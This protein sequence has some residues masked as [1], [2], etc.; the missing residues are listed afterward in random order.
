NSHFN[1]PSVS[2]SDRFL[3]IAAKVTSIRLDKILPDVLV[4]AML[5]IGSSSPENILFPALN[6]LDC[7]GNPQDDLI[8]GL[9]AGSP[10]MTIFISGGEQGET[11]QHTRRLLSS[12]LATQSQVQ[13]IAAD[14]MAVP[15]LGLP[16]V[17]QAP[18]LRSLAYNGAFT[19]GD[20]AKLIQNCQNLDS[21]TFEGFT[22]G[23]IAPNPTASL[24]AP[25]L[26]RLDLAGLD[27]SDITI[28]IL[29]S[30]I[31]PQLM[32]LDVTLD[33]VPLFDALQE[34]PSAP[35][36]RSAFRLLAE[37]SHCLESLALATSITLRA[38]VLAAFRS[39]RSLDI[40]DWTP[41]CQLDDSDIHSLCHSL[42]KLRRF[43]LEY[44][45]SRRPLSVDTKITPKSFGFFARYTT[46]LTY[47]GLPVNAAKPEDF[48][49][50]ILTEL[51]PFQKNLKH[52]TLTPLTLFADRTKDVVSFLLVQCPNLTELDIYLDVAH[53]WT[54]VPD[55]IRI[56]REM[57]STYFQ[58]QVK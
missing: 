40:H 34:D 49:G 25:S 19:I 55:L 45:I 9:F 57:R 41:G 16:E 20:W 11:A 24:P 35:R 47:L 2:D 23:T 51:V 14:E 38:K 3:S 46:E 27:S 22:F 53:S 43:Y 44:N 26:R 17:W 4:K 6:T 31:A 29:E 28:D 15:G 10:I 8:C 21:V 48:T 42:P 18:E 37:R 33:P 5:E 12:L 1:G 36:A 50:S 58:R 54:S 39:L 13:S 32:E 7:G 52:L 30:T 56:E